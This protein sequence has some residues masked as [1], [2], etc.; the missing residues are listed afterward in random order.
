MSEFSTFQH[1]AL[2]AVVDD[3]WGIADDNGILF[4]IKEDLA[5]FQRLTTSHTV[6]M[7]RKTFEQL[8]DG[9][10]PCR[11]N[12]ILTRMAHEWHHPEHGIFIA[13]MGELLH[14]VNP[15]DT[16]VIGGEEVYRELYPYCNRAYITMV[17]TGTPSTATKRF[18]DL[19][20]EKDWTIAMSTSQRMSVDQIHNEPVSYT[21]Y[22][23]VRKG[24]CG[25][26]R[27]ELEAWVNATRFDSNGN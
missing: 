15:Y 14:V 8:P 9:P 16:F 7:G 20:K 10:L 5:F 21:H 11:H 12:V 4:R 19:C 23:F 27:G 24:F 17:H 6:V 22:S 1:M 2:I 26:Q 13:D 25:Y 3:Y 18:P